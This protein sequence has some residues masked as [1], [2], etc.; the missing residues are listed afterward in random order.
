[1][2]VATL[3]MNS[4]AA[5]QRLMPFQKLD[6]NNDGRISNREF[7]RSDRIF[8]QKDI[9]QDGYLSPQ[10]IRGSHDERASQNNLPA[11]I[12]TQTTQSELLY[13]DTHNH[14][15]GTRIQG[16]GGASDSTAVAQTALETMNANGV[17]WNL[18]MP[19]PQ[20]VS[21][22]TRLYIDDNCRTV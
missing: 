11:P 2:F 7:K 4:L 18:V 19:M 15:V 5:A 14:L 20:G 21:Q 1:M 6:R 10:E 12:E 22:K 17:Q 13:V 16:K 9:N 3:L 8:E